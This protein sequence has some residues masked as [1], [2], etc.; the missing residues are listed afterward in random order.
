MYKLSILGSFIIA[1]TLASGTVLAQEVTHLGVKSH[2]IVNLVWVPDQAAICPD[3]N[4]GKKSFFRVKATGGLETT[5][6]VVPNGSRLVI[7]DVIWLAHPKPSGDFVAGEFLRAYLQAYTDNGVLGGQIYQ[8]SDVVVQVTDSALLGDSDHISG[9]IALAPTRQ[10]CA[11]ANAQIPSG[12]SR[13]HY[14]Q[15]IQVMGYL[16][17]IN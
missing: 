9:G 14:P 17:R 2:R 6:F 1:I 5:P 16:I 11:T 8:A 4:Q 7:T 15:E 10:L 3:N 12:G 13:I